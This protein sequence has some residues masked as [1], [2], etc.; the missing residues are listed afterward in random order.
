MYGSVFKMRALPGKEQE[1]LQTGEQWQREYGSSTPGY[2]GEYVYQLDSDPRAFVVAVLFESR[3]AY[4]K[5]ADNPRQ[6]AF[7][8][9]MRALLEADPEWNDGQVVFAAP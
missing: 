7:Y 9:R 6:G 3:E 8:Q 1:L 5:N 4:L 2:V